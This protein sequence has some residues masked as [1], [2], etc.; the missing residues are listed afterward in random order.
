MNEAVRERILESLS[1]AMEEFERMEQDSPYNTALD[2]S[3]AYSIVSTYEGETPVVDEDL[4]EELGF[5][6]LDE[7]ESYEPIKPIEVM[8]GGE[9]AEGF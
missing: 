9:E 5:T 2:L 7:L 8:S 1:I 6:E 3:L 4:M